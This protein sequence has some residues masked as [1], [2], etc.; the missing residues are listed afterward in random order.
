MRTA[1]VCLILGVMLMAI[2]KSEA[3]TFGAPIPASCCFNFI[4]FQIPVDKVKSAVRTNSSCTNKAVV[5]T[6]VKGNMFCVKP[7]ETWLQKIAIDKF[8]QIMRTAYVC[9]ILGVM[10]MATLK[11][12]AQPFAGPVPAICCFNFIGF[13]IPVDKVKSAVRTSSY[14]TNKAVVVT[15]VKGNMFCVKPDEPWLQKITIA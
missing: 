12:E 8:N 4:D 2:L 5:V 15:T 14:C 3:Q 13:P 10:L 7:E 9:L 11:S 1:Y 6:T